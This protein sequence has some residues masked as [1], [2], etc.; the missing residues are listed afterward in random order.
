MPEGEGVKSPNATLAPMAKAIFVN[1]R[2]VT[3]LINAFSQLFLLISID[4]RRSESSYRER[5]TTRQTDIGRLSELFPNVSQS[6]GAT[7]LPSATQ[8]LPPPRQCYPGYAQDA[9][10]L[11]ADAS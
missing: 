3:E 6:V 10:D 9:F 8:P 5:T 11:Q 7:L 2:R 4:N 1:V